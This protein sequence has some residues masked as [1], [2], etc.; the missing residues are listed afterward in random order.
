MLLSSLYHC[1]Y[2]ISLLSSLSYPLSFSCSLC[3]Y[4]NI[5]V[6]C[7]QAFF[8][9]FLS[10]GSCVSCLSLNVAI[11]NSVTSANL[12]AHCAETN[13]RIFSYFIEVV[14]HLSLML[15]C[16][17]NHCV[18]LSFFVFLSFVIIIIPHVPCYCNRHIVQNSTIRFVQ[19]AQ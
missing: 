1:V 2:C 14:N 9:L 19:C 10:L 3:I 11:V 6:L 18:N 13:V 15:E 17:C 16:L 5:I 8:S 4:Y 7:C 12:K